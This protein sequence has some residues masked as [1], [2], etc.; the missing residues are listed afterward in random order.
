MHPVGIEAVVE[1]TLSPPPKSES[2]HFPLKPNRFSRQ[3][4]KRTGENG[5][6]V[7]RLRMSDSYT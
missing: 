4:M 3:E 5:L 2:G 1:V 6:V 7:M